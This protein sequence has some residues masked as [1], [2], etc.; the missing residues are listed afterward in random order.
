[1]PGVSLQSGCPLW[2]SDSCDFWCD[3]GDLFFRLLS[4]TQLCSLCKKVSKCV[5][6]IGAYFCI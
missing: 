5:L 1:M 2:D 3:G 6:I 4:V